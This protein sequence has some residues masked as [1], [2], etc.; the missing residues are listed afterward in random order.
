MISDIAII[1]SDGFA[2]RG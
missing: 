2:Y 1:Y